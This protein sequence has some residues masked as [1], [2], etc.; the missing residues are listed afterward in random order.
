MK[1]AEAIELLKKTGLYK[2]VRFVAKTSVPAFWIPYDAVT[3][4]GDRHRMRYLREN[5]V[6]KLQIGCGGNYL[7]GWFNTDLSPNAHRTGLNAT[8]RFPFADNTFDYI[9]SEHMIEHVPYD[10]GRVILSECHRVLKPG[11]TLRIVTPDLKFLIGLYQ[12][13]N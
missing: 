7:E 13:D 1:R 3:N 4:R 12:N 5:T 8:R 6:H 11:G 10:M 9:L 2:P